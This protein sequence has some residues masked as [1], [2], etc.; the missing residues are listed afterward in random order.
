M[1]IVFRPFST[2]RKFCSKPR[3]LSPNL[4]STN[5]PTQTNDELKKKKLNKKKTLIQTN[6]LRIRIA[7][8]NVTGFYLI[9]MNKKIYI[10]KK[11][12]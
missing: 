5:Q 8:M 6:I 12:K 7:G 2:K 10:W 3:N 11:E 9:K 4:K 1:E